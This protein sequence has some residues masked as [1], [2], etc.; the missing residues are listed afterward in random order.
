MEGDKVGTS[1]SKSRKIQSHSGHIVVVHGHSFTVLGPSMYR[2]SLPNK[3][4]NIE[5]TFLTSCREGKEEII[6]V[7][8]DQF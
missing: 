6:L 2:E 7:E 1:H 8:E 5:Y 4:K 3:L